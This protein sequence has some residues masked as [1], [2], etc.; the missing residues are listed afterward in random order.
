MNV[1]VLN[2]T[3]DFYRY[4]DA[5]RQAEFL[6]DCVRQTA[7]RILPDEIHYLTADEEDRHVVAQANSP[8]DLE[9]QRFTE[10]RVL[11]RTK[12]GEVDFVAPSTW[13][14]WTSP[15][16]RWCRSRRP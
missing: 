1:H 6:F 16:A 10:G 13:T 12:G 8:I 5:T 14:S 9:S 7:E 3:G 4:F 2:D 11:V 15:R